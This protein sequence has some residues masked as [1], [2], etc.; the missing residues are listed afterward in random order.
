[1]FVA[2]NDQYLGDMQFMSSGSSET[3]VAGTIAP[4]EA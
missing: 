1:M 2:G 3:F 4:T